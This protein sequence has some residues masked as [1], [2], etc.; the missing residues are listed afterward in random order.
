M[1]N[2]TRV[3]F[4]AAVAMVLATSATAGPYSTD[5]ES[6]TIGP[7]D[8]QDGWVNDNY[9]Y[10]AIDPM[11]ANDPTGGGHGKVLQIDPPTDELDYSWS[12][13]FRACGDLVDEGAT[14]F[15]LSWDQ[16]RTGFADIL[17]IVENPDLTGWQAQEWNGTIYPISTDLLPSA[18]LTPQQWQNIR[19]AFDVQ[20]GTL[21]GFL[22][23]V[24]L[25]VATDKTFDKFRGMDFQ[26]MVTWGG[27]AGPNYI[28]NVSLTVIPEP[29]T[30]VLLGIGAISLLAYTWRRRRS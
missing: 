5:F 16:W 10:S 26:V 4:A 24:S 13:A 22:D 1:F 25:G 21:E 3:V 11:I 17:W 23:N 2:A 14:K 30:F 6:F 8:G 15:E 7:V 12:A 18:D 20:A 9:G 29:S 19:L 28:D 27:V